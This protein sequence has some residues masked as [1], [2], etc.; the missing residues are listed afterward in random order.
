MNRGIYLLA[1]GRLPCY[2]GSGATIELGRL[3][4]RARPFDFVDDYYLG[5][6]FQ[7]IRDRMA[8][9][10]TAWPG[11]CDQC[12]YLDPDGEYEEGLLDREVEWFH[13]EPSYLCMLD[14][15]WCR[16]QR[17]RRGGA[18]PYAPGLGPCS[19]RW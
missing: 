17:N 7:R 9:G 5:G 14:C 16:G 4:G 12:T 10:L 3:P 11:V 19:S 2:C 13:W 1:D 18:R 6:K 15:E 8:S